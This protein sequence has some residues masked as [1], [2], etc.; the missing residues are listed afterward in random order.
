MDYI[1]DGV[2]KGDAKRIIDIF[3]HYIDN[4]PAAY[5][6]CKVPYEFFNHFIRLSEGFPFLV[7]R[8]DDGSVLGFGLLRPHNPIPAF[9]HAAE[10][11]CFISP[12]NTG[13]GI[14]GQILDALV[15]RSSEMGITTILASISSLNHISLSFHKKHGFLECG[16]FLKVGRKRGMDFD[17]VWMQKMVP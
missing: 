15:S 4:S 9:S 3:N 1:I 8:G 12:E 14:G 16:R 10:F 17:L 11:T 7:A 6:D 13:K 2:Q 5:M